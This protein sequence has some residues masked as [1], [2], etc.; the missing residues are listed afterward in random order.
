MIRTPKIFIAVFIVILICTVIVLLPDKK[1]NSNDRVMIVDFIEE[2][3]SEIKMDNTEQPY[4]LV[5]NDGWFVKDSSSSLDEPIKNM[6]ADILSFDGIL[7]GSDIADA[8]EY[9]IN[10]DS[11]RMTY[12]DKNNE[13][14]SF[15]LGNKT[16]SGT[17]YYIADDNNDVY[18]IYTAPGDALKTKKYLLEDSYIL[19]IEYEDISK[20]TV[21]GEGPFE[22]SKS[23]SKWTLIG[24]NEMQTIDEFTVRSDVTRHF[25][26]MYSMATY[27]DNDENNEKFG[28]NE[29]VQKVTITD[30]DGNI[31]TFYIADEE[32]KSV[33]IKLNEEK[34][35]Y[36]VVKDYFEFIKQYRE[37]VY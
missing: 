10:E 6:L 1:M 19:G 23:G 24:N 5:N 16:P 35:I 22:L 30:F 28:F 11:L 13:S 4:S 25:G 15:T 37:G 3:L 29:D 12:I 31:N 20:I 14:V 18:A 33:Y 34:I 32:G 36:S 8:S 26:G 7:V 21:E 2:D 27:P 17:E 9:G